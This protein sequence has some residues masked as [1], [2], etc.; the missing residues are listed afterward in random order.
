MRL[1]LNKT[2][3]YDLQA[4]V[5][6]PE[7]QTVSEAIAILEREGYSGVEWEQLDGNDERLTYIAPIG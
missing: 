7:A 6:I 4:E 2:V 3:S 1:S 5:D